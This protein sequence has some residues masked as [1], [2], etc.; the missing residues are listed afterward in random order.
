MYHEPVLLHEST[1]GLAIKAEG[2][3]VDATFGGGGHS[4]AILS[5]LGDKGRLIAIDQDEAVKQ[6]LPQDKRLTFVH[7]NFRWIEN[8]L[9]YF[10]IEKVDGILAD[11][12]VSWHH[13]SDN[14]RGFSFMGNEELD[15]RMNRRAG[16]TAADL[17]ETCSAQQ[18][19][20]IFR[21][22]GELDH[23]SRF[24]SEIIAQRSNCNIRMTQ[25]LVDICSKFTNRN[26]R[27]KVLA[28]I[29]QA[30]RIEVNDEMGAL[31]DFLLACSRCIAVGGRLSVIS[32]H[33]LEDRLVKN[34]M[35]TGNLE[36]RIKH[37]MYGMK[38]IAWETINRKVITAADE[39]IAVNPKARSA[40]LR[41]AQRKH[42]A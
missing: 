20:D 19:T 35:K 24:A 3:Y 10:E 26:N 22:Y 25:N 38:P 11:L 12:G 27:N 33:S 5:K 8:Y 18:L 1:E 23:A 6:N 13:F 2:I 37:D 31:T 17:L 41:I 16:K 29:F 32:Y 14:S 34:L 39:E 9:E 30:L 36:G 42:D 7:G 4:R 28:Q 40:K 21:N 15:M